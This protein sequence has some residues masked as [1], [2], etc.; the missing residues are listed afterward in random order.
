LTYEHAG[1]RADFVYSRYALHHLPD[2]WKSV[3][4]ERLHRVLAPGGV[5]RLWDIVYSFEPAEAEDR[6]AAWCATGATDVEA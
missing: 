1:P 4:L 2:F 3:A 5:L 6:L